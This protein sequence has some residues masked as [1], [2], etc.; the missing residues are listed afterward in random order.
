MDQILLDPG[1]REIHERREGRA[2][3]TGP[4]P[5]LEGNPSIVKE[6]EEARLVAAASNVCTSYAR[7]FTS[8]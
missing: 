6:R 1:G 8:V 5:M 7:G 2:P 3:G 4:S